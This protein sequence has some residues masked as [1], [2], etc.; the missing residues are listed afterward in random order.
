MVL[1]PKFGCRGPFFFALIRT[2]EK[3]VYAAEEFKDRACG[4]LHEAVLDHLQRN[5]GFGEQFVSDLT[6]VVVLLVPIQQV[7]HCAEA[8]EAYSGTVDA[9]SREIDRSATSDLAG[10]DRDID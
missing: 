7:E 10:I 1:R 5:P 2:F 3:P 4:F 8:L 9:L 6:S